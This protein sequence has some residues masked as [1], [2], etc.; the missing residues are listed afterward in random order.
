[1]D[2]GRDHDRARHRRRPARRRD[3]VGR[4]AVRRRQRG[5]GR[6]P[7]RPSSPPRGAPAAGRATAQPRPRDARQRA[8][9]PQLPSAVLL[10][11]ACVVVPS[12]FA[13][14][15]RAVR[16]RG[17]PSRVRS[18]FN[19]ESGYNDRIVSP[20]FLFTLILANVDHEDQTPLDAL[21]PAAP[22]A[23]TALVVGV[24]VGSALAA[25]VDR[26]AAAGWIT[27]QARRI[28]VLLA[29]LLIF[30]LTVAVG[31]NGFVASFIG[32]VAFR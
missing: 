3:H 12:E 31:G 20:L 19:V 5:P 16:D 6:S 24:M 8:A 7:I 18:A 4:A 28:V 25:A 30:R 32:G 26:A 2:R 17:L 1:M 27:D 14:A 22:F 13:P 11:V 21:G 23:T 29:P 15:E 9:V 10:I